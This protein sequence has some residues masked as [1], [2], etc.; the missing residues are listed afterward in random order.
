MQND[1]TIPAPVSWQASTYWDGNDGIWNSFILNAGTPPQSFRV[2]PS[3]AGQETWLPGSAGFQDSRS[4]QSSTWNVNGIFSVNSPQ[5][6]LGYDPTGYYGFDTVTLGNGN[7][8]GVLD[9]TNQVVAA[10]PSLNFW[11]GYF[12]LGPRSVNFTSFNDPVP[13]FMRDLV[14]QQRIPSLSWGYTAGAYYRNNAHA[15]LTLGGYDA[16]R[17]VD[18]KLTISM[19]GDDSRPLQAAIEAITVENT[20]CGS[21][22]NLHFDQ[23]FYF[24]DSTVPHI[25]LPDDVVDRFV[26]C[27]G[28]TYDNNTDL[29]LVNDTVRSQLLDLNPTVTFTFSNGTADDDQD[30][31]NIALP[32][33]ALDLQASYPYYQT[34][35]NYF[36]IRRAANN[37]QYTIGR[38]LLQEAYVIA[39]FEQ[40]NFTIAQASFDNLDAPNLVAIRTVSNS[41]SVSTSESNPGSSSLS[42]G[43]IAG[44]VVGAIVAMA[45]I[46]GVVFFFV[47]RHRRQATQRPQISY[48]PMTELPDEGRQRA[49]LPAE[50]AVSEPPQ[51]DT[52]LASELP[53]SS[54]KVEMEG[55]APAHEL[56]AVVKR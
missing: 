29:F 13:S 34:A 1:T 38:T 35:T 12:G 54:A 17:F 37:T 47:R 2:F 19:N 43:A 51:S 50:Y 32:Y 48:A 36:P 30:L 53:M 8:T 27:F 11:T 24:I 5:K 6:A 33:A 49:E 14:T 46:A 28:L 55:S 20:L 15:S 56:P 52:S 18:T 41:P 45:I 10:I 31:V 25:W 3:T 9:L 40:N 23:T 16:M 7:S 21:A 26:N 39:D 4:N 44:I 42:G 22:S